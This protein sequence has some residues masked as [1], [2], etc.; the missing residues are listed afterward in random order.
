MAYGPKQ[1][2]CCAS[3]DGVEAHH[4][5]SRKLGC[6]RRSD[7]VAVLPREAWLGG[8]CVRDWSDQEYSRYSPR[9]HGRV[10]TF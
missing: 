6:P 4:L 3:A 9:G 1:C 5:Y 8:R 2:G 10:V 7:G